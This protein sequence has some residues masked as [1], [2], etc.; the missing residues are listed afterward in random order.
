MPSHPFRFLG[1]TQMIHGKHRLV[2]ATLS[3]LIFKE[4]R[5]RMMS[6]SQSPA[7]CTCHLQLSIDESA[8]VDEFVGPLD[9]KHMTVVLKNSRSRY[10]ITK[11]V[12]VK[13]NWVPFILV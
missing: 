6:V 10:G 2:K 4:F 3:V 8:Q 13:E 5:R 1:K 11:L 12:A 9:Q 7:G